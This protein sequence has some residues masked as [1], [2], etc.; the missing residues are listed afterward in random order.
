MPILNGRTTLTTILLGSVIPPGSVTSFAGNTAPAGWL[1]CDGSLVSRTTYADLF[2]SIGTIHGSGDGTT[3]FALPDYR[4]R[5]I[6]GADNMGTG[7][8]GRDPNAATRTA[9]NSGGNTG[10]NVGSVQS[11]AMQL[12]TGTISSARAN[13]GTQSGVFVGPTRSG[14]YG[15]GE[16]TTD[17][18][19]DFDNSRVARTSSENRPQNAYVF[20]I[21]KV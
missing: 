2:A 10:N 13:F 12:M 7:A 6:R 18:R 14:E 1:I 9:S 8:A 4:G 21:I 5:F 19:I 17:G 20:Y 16:V 11:D 3:T 15:R